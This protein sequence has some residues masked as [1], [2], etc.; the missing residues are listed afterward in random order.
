MASALNSALGLVDLEEETEAK[1]KDDSSSSSSTGSKVT[2]CSFQFADLLT[3]DNNIFTIKATGTVGE[4]EMTLTA[5]L[6][7]DSSDPTKWKT[8]YYRL[9]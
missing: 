9:D 1:G 3:K 2:G 6:N 5:V 4:T 7:T 8:Y